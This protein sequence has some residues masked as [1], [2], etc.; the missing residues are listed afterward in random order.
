VNRPDPIA[1][2]NHLLRLLFRSLPVYVRETQL[3]THGDARGL[4]VLQT[5]AADRKRL[6]QRLAVA[7]DQRGG[8][9]DAGRFPTAFT[10]LNDVS[11]E[12]LLDRVRRTAEEEIPV[13]QGCLVELEGDPEAH[14]LAAEILA[15]ACK[16]QEM[17]EGL[18]P[19]PLQKSC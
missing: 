11:L 12:Y 1:V 18:K 13:L 9:V 2:L 3:W 15:N 4:A 14:A 17:L 6:A 5:M 8:A 16:H 19:A 10:G 7:I